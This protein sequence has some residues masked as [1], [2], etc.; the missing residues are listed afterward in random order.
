MDMEGIGEG[1]KINGGRF[2]YGGG[3][4]KEAQRARRM[5]RNMHQC[6]VGDREN[7]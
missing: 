7:L 3:D 5:N 6:E 2:R 4:R 1:E